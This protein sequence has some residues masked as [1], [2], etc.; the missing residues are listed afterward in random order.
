MRDACAQAR[1]PSDLQLSVVRDTLPQRQ[2][3][4]SDLRF[5]AGRGLAGG[6][7]HIR[8]VRADLGGERGRDG[9][10]RG[11]G[12]ADGREGE[13][14]FETSCLFFLCRTWCNF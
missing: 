8:Q 1:Y 5:P 3:T 6:K 2:L 7:G 11:S 13:S 14:A 12:G 9:V 4:N 10:V